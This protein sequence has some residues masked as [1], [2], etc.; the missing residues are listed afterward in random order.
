MLKQ[1]LAVNTIFL[2]ISVALVYLWTTHPTSSLYTL[3]LVALFLLAYFVN[4]FMQARLKSIPSRRATLTINAV[5]FSTVILLLVASTGGLGSPLFFLIYFLLFGV[6]LM[7]EPDVAISLTV[8]LT[9]FFLILPTDEPL[10]S[11]FIQISSIVLLAP[12]AI[13]F[14][15]EYLKLLEAERKIT[16]LKKDSKSLE[17]QETDS[18]LWLSLNL[19]SALHSILDYS[20]L[21]LSGLG[22]LSFQQKELVNKIRQQ[23]RELL[24]SGQELKDK[25]DRETD[26]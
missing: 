18:L 17:H 20:S 11:Y 3:Q 26:K 22:K 16:I 12:L 25:I 21:L 5:I 13:F 1:H 9:I 24:Q 2:I 8:I 23:T 14:G 15:R 6:S 19:K 4:Y 7:F 10:A